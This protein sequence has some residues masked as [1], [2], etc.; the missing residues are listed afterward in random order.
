MSDSEIENKKPV[1]E[2]GEKADLTNNQNFVK[3]QGNL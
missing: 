1:D 3:F 2:N